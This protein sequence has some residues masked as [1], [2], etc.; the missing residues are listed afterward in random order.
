[1]SK[2]VK[3][4]RGNTIEI[5]N[6]VPA[7][8]E[9]VVNTDDWSLIVGDGLTKGGHAVKITVPDTYYVTGLV[10][11]DDVS[12]AF[13]AVS[14]LKGEK[15]GRIVVPYVGNLRVSSTLEIPRNTEVDFSGNSLK[16]DTQANC[17]IIRNTNQGAAISGW[18]KLHGIN[19]LDGNASGGQTRKLVGT[20]AR[21]MYCG[22]GTLFVGV[23]LLDVQINKTVDTE[24]WAHAY[25]LCGQVYY[26]DMEF[27]QGTRSGMNGDGVTGQAVR[28]FYKNFWGYTNDDMCAV[29]SRRASIQGVQVWNQ[30]LGRPMEVVSVE[31]IQGRNST[32]ISSRKSWVGFGAYPSDGDTIGTINLKNITGDWEV[33]TWRVGNYFSSVGA[34]QGTIR[35]MN[36]EGCD[37]TTY[38]AND[39]MQLLFEAKIQRLNISGVR[40]SAAQLVNDTPFLYASRNSSVSYLTLNGCYFNVNSNPVN[41]LGFVQTDAT[42]YVKHSKFIGNTYD[43]PVTLAI[44]GFCWLNSKNATETTRATFSG[45]DFGGV[46][47]IS[48]ILVLKKIHCFRVAAPFY[49][50]NNDLVFS[51]DVNIVSSE[52]SAGS[53]GFSAVYSSGWIHLTGG[54][55]TVN[56]AQPANETN[57]FT[58]PSWAKPLSVAGSISPLTYSSQTATNTATLRIKP[59]GSVDIVNNIGTAGIAAVP[60]SHVQFLSSNSF[61]S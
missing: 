58:L 26:H 28:T 22:F 37:T 1:M 8:A 31:N 46:P 24:A 3:R 56:S 60:F 25:F 15:A 39:A 12:D 42:S 21:D 17:Y 47:R 51:E 49:L 44:D 33:N 45:N 41:P 50:G 14:A 9:I 4:R 55:N 32:T 59:N 18:I 34:S 19:K 53:Y 40:G 27:I 57:A 54:A 11:G 43:I 13:N 35:E 20:D 5:S 38:K 30:G 2:V 6:A 16:L 36:V 23:E 29:T 48:S 52:W 10:D 7:V 61:T